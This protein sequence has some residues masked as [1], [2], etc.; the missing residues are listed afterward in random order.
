MNFSMFNFFHILLI[1]NC[2]DS[3]QLIDYQ[4]SD[5][6]LPQTSK[7]LNQL[8]K[9]AEDLQQSPTTDSLIHSVSP[10][11]YDH[12]SPEMDSYF[13]HHPESSA[14]QYYNFHSERS[15]LM[16]PLEDNLDYVDDLP[17]EIPTG[18]IK[19][20]D[21]MNLEDEDVTETDGEDDELVLSNF[22]KTIDNSGK[23]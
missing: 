15:N 3:I 18:E 5:L 20:S 2:L 21:N 11:H 17:D 23:N 4:K 14:H 1:L 8:T 10:D 19:Y 22:H 6:N 16:E 13:T 7:L 9:K 12:W